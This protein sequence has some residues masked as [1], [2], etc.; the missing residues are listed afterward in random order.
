MA[1]RAVPSKGAK[2]DKL[3]RDALMLAV[4]R[5][6]KDDQ[7]KKVKKLALIANK[8]VDLAVEGDVQA[9]RE[10]ADRID[11]K[12]TQ[13]LEHGGPDGGAIPFE[14]IERVIVDPSPNAKD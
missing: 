6:G 3:I 10:V 7:G 11:G 14:R 12:P 2:P 4:N 8:L 13:A 9:I 5:E 1:A